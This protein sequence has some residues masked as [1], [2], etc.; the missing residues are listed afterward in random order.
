[1]LKEDRTIK[2]KPVCDASAAVKCDVSLNQSLEPEPN[3]IELIPIMLL[4]F[5]E[6]IIGVIS[7]IKKAFL[8]ISISP[9]DRDVLRLL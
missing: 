5:R 6:K 1:M 3:L 8:Q 9:K 4:R 2:M 7:D